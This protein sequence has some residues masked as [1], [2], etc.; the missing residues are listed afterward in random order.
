MRWTEHGAQFYLNFVTGAFLNIHSNFHIRG[1]LW[2]VVGKAALN[3][4]RRLS[5]IKYLYFVS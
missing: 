5:L 1:F 2:L 3:Y 4:L